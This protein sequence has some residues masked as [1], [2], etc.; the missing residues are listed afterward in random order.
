MGCVWHLFLLENIISLREVNWWYEAQWSVL[1]ESGCFWGGGLSHFLLTMKTFL[2]HI[3]SLMWEE[4]SN[5][6]EGRGDGWLSD[7]DA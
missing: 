5:S 7:K 4:K 6:S 1:Y 3:S 2:A